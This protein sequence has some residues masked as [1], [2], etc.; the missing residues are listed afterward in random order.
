MKDFAQNVVTFNTEVIG[1]KDRTK[2]LLGVDELNFTTV[3]L[4]EEIGEF[5]DAHLEK[6]YIGAIDALI[7]LMYFAI[8]GLHKLGLTVN[9][10][11]LCAQAV[12][13]CNMTKKRGVVARRNQENDAVKPAEWVGPEQRIAAILEGGK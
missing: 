13:E 7:D 8:G 2:E 5:E 12:H 1:I 6:D 4:R 10:M 11:E 3:A 9:E